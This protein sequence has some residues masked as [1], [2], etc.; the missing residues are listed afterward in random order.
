MEDL[1]WIKPG[2]AAWEWWN[3]CSLYGV[4]FI[5]GIN[6][7]TYKYYIRFAADNNLEYIVIDAG[8]YKG[9]DI[10]DVVDELNLKEL[11]EYGRVYAG[12]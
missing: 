1:S 8:W 10:L 5:A 6:N 2:K 9:T 7:E 11:V 12:Y 4:D 3:S